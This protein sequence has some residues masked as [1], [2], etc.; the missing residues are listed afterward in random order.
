[1]RTV[2]AARSGV[3]AVL[4]LL[5]AACTPPAPPEAW[6]VS[7]RLLALPDDE[8]SLPARCRIGDEIRPALGCP[9]I[10]P[11]FVAKKQPE[12]G[13]AYMVPRRNHRKAV[14]FETS[15]RG[16]TNEPWEVRRRQIVRRA[17]RR[18]ETNLRGP[19]ELARVRS[20]L[21]PPSETS[22]QTS[23]Q[24][25]FD[26][27]VLEGAIA[28]HPIV[29]A[30]L[31]VP[32]EFRITAHTEAGSRV[33]FEHVL[34]PGGNDRWLDYAIVLDE[35]AGEDVLLEFTTRFAAPPADP[36]GFAIPVWSR[37]SLLRK[38]SDPP[39]NI[40]VVS[41][42]T[43]RADHVGVYG[44]PEGSTPT[45]DALAGESTVFDRAY[46]TFPS[47]TASHMSLFTGLY[48]NVHA[49]LGP[50]KLLARG[51]RTLAQVL[52]DGGYRTAAVTENGMILADAGFARGFD[53]Y[54]EFKEA[55]AF[56]TSGHF[57]QVLDVATRW[58]E[59]H[60]DDLFH[61]FLHTYQVHDPYTPP[62]KWDVFSPDAGA[63]NP[64][65]ERKRARYR[66]EILYT[67]EQMARLLAVLDRLGLADRTILVVTSDHGE[68]FGERGVVGHG[69]N[70]TQ[71]LL[72]IPLV[73]RAP[74]LLSPGVR[75]DDLVSLIDL[76]PSLLD[77]AGLPI[78]PEM[79]G[80]PA[81]GSRPMANPTRPIYGESP[82]RRAVV[83]GDR[84]WVVDTSTGETTTFELSS[85]E[86]E[87]ELP[88]TPALLARGRAL[89]EEIDLLAEHARARLD[90]A[91]PQAIDVDDETKTQLRALGYVE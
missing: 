61:L 87:T 59:R 42:D 24:P 66:G 30:D 39:W 88:T 58:L 5:V 51:I 91:E 8:K 17:R 7:R 46:T 4:A 11:L 14:L 83:E 84:K 78:P 31:S 23:R 69:W 62:R 60:R 79:Q 65:L 21:L 70:V 81:L 29:P 35:L 56:E 37:P 3:G 53:S 27:A 67:D 55:R 25:M 75:V 33:V 50:G 2:K 89:F 10:D 41:L 72:R 90:G 22:R 9:R 13:R 32:I 20:V 82:F 28:L 16:A 15:M 63:S 19:T 48:P 12:T 68:A 6:V 1:M 36:P 86:G 54:T 57:A 80:R 47:T 18:Y 64:D 52:A 76:A 38:R 71:E 49:V 43:L 73:V 74:G 77:L 34:T 85:T 40:V 44:A 45:L 26:D